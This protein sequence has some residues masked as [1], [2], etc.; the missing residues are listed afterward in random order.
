MVCVWFSLM[1]S[2]FV[3]VCC[4][5]C[6]CVELMCVLL[7]VLLVRICICFSRCFILSM[8]FSVGFV[9]WVF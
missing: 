7:R 5:L 6:R 9:L 4:L 2:W 1:V 8:C 3:C